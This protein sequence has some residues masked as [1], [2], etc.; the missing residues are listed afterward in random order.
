LVI[1]TK[2]LLNKL[3]IT[4]G[5]TFNTPVRH[6]H[7]DDATL[8]ETPIDLTGASIRV[9]I[10]KKEADYETYIHADISTANG[11]LVF[12]DAVN[13]KFKFNVSATETRDWKFD[14]GFLEFE[15][16]YADLTVR[17]KF[18]KCKLIREYVR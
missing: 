3:T 4:Q 17:K 9:Q 8:V 16:T 10:R 18:I 12:T 15:Y 11:K 1:V 14:D 6:Y 7:L 2:K 5:A 13:G